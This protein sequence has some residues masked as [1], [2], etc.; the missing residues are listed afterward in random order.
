MTDI[1][2]I[3]PDTEPDCNA[4]GFGTFLANCISRVVTGNADNIVE[5]FLITLLFIGLG[6]IFWNLVHVCVNFF[7]LK[8]RTQPPHRG[9][10]RFRNGMHRREGYSPLQVRRNEEN[11]PEE[12]SVVEDATDIR[13]AGDSWD[14]DEYDPDYDANNDL[15]VM[16]LQDDA[17][18][19]AED[20]NLAENNEDGGHDILRR[21]IMANSDAEAR[22]LAIAGNASNANHNDNENVMERVDQDPNAA[23]MSAEERNES[24]NQSE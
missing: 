14:Q 5:V 7:Q 8:R 9:R 22:L 11:E 20:D 16:L 12:P 13:A 10:S 4:P 15:I 2:T 1:S 24:V 17:D 19:S 23:E 3:C 18:N 21:I 6:L